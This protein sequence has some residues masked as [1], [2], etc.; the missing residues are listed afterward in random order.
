MSTQIVRLIGKLSIPGGPT[1][2]DQ[3]RVAF[4]EEI[5][6]DLIERGAA[7]LVTIPTKQLSTPPTD[8]MVKSPDTQKGGRAELRERVRISV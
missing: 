1:Y 5:A 7:E 4:D 3:E 2:N 8:K 6:Q